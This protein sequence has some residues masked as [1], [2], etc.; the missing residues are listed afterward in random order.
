MTS[1]TTKP[2]EASPLRRR[3]PLLLIIVVGTVVW[4]SGFGFFAT[5]RTV[6][7][8]L[9]V[10]AGDV[11]RVI[12]EL[13]SGD[14]LLR[15]EERQTPTGLTAELSQEVPLRRGPHQAIAL[16]WLKGG[17]EPRVLKREFDPGDADAV[18]IEPKA[19]PAAAPPR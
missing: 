4:K 8:R 7:W 11:R 1:L 2:S 10:P 16:I 6:T 12:L 9:Q 18:V 5:T 3:L 13:R 14:A 19:Q 15:R 17:S